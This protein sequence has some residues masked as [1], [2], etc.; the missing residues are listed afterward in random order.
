[1]LPDPE[2]RSQIQPD[3]AP[4]P[5]SESYDPDDNRLR[6]RLAEAT[7]RRLSDARRAIAVELRLPEPL[8]FP[9]LTPSS[10]AGSFRELQCRVREEGATAPLVCER[11][12]ANLIAQAREERSIEW[13][14][15]KA[16]SEGAWRTAREWM[17]G[18]AARRRGHQKGDPLPPAPRPRREPQAAPIVV[19]QDERA[20]VAAMVAELRERLAGRAS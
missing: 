12:V 11:V 13:L 5:V 10:R 8:P 6:G 14:A 4:L 19:P 17:P 3:A 9:P 7:Y 15:E 2:P 16:F 18:A 1:M 20:E